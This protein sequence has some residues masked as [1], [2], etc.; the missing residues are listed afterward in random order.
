MSW[1]KVREHIDHQIGMHVIHLEH[2]FTKAQHKLQIWLG[3]DACPL[4]GHVVPKTNTGELDP[5]AFVAQEIAALERVHG[6]IEAYARKHRVPIRR[7][8]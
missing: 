7:H 1:S 5:H 8:H 2:A 3:M 6:N 4:C